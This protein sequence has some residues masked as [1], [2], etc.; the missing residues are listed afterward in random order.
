M[1][2]CGFIYIVLSFPSGQLRAALDKA[3]VVL[4]IAGTLLQVVAMLFGSGSGLRCGGGC[5][6]NLIQIFHDNGLALSAAQPAAGARRDP[7]ADRGRRC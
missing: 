5:G 1:F 7:D 3:I 4:A 2:L 6:D